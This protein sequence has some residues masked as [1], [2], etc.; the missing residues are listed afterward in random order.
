MAP[1][2]KKRAK[3]NV[4]TSK[5]DILSF[6]GSAQSQGA[7]SNSKSEEKPK[8]TKLKETKPKETTPKKMKPKET[9]PKETKTKTVINVEG[10][11]QD[12]GKAKPKFKC[13]TF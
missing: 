9:K 8:E 2:P 1:P 11:G 4:D 10:E 6:F 7:T 12:G 3:T 5:H 13:A